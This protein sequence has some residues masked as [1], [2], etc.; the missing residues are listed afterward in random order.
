VCGAAAAGNH[1]RQGLTASCHKRY[2][3]L[4]SKGCTKSDPKSRD[5]QLL[6][7]SFH[8]LYRW[9]N[10]SI[11]SLEQDMINYSNPRSDPLYRC[12]AKQ[13]KN[14]SYQ[15]RSRFLSSWLLD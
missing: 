5:D 4:L 12:F 3:F 8:Q 7:P 15:I 13:N 9:T 2:E 10:K 6:Q 11:C 1:P 14:A